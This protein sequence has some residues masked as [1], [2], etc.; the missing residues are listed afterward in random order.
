M[1]QR[2]DYATVAP[3]A[4]GAMLQLERHV[5][6][7]GIEESLLHL[8]KLRASQL[9]GCA[10]CVDMHSKD[11]RAAGESEQRLHL[12]TVWREA[13]CYTERE[14]AALD[15]TEVVTRIGEGLMSDEVFE[16]VRR[17]F[18]EEELVELTL[19]IIAINGWNRLATSF[20][21]PVGSYEPPSRAKRDGGGERVVVNT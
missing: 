15:W 14:R 11:A 3:A 18:G 6:Q 12:L 20:R 17:E 16:S 8:L 21:A 9:N 1:S 10:Y 4:F 13:P 7:S 19:A 2:L 5:R